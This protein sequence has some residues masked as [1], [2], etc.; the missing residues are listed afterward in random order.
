MQNSLFRE[1]AIEHQKCKL[2]GEVLIVPAASHT[3]VVLLLTLWVC[4]VFAWMVN[5]QYARQET[6]TGWLEPPSGVIK[7]FSN[8]LQGKIEQVLVT[9]G[10][11]VN[12]GQELVIVSSDRTLASGSS[13]QATL[14]QEYANQKQMLEDQL[15]RLDTTDAIDI[16]NIRRK[17]FA[18]QQDLTGLEAQ[19][20]TLSQRQELMDIRYNNFHTMRDEGHLA[21]IELDKMLEQKLALQSEAQALQREWVNLSNHLQLLESELITAPQTHLNESRQL[22]TKLS[23]L[24]LNIAQLNSQQSV[25]IKAS[26][27]GVVSNLQ[28]NVGHQ[29]LAKTPLLSLVPKDSL[30]Q[31]RLLVPIKAAGFIEEGQTIEVRYDAFPYQKFGLYEG[32]IT[33]ISDA[34][35]LPGELEFAPLNVNEP[36]Y[37]VYADLTSQTVSAYGKPLSL[38][39]GMTLSADVTLS[40][41]NL[42]EWVLEPLLSLKGRM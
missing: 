31:A 36:V 40:D 28:A 26:R 1:N 8:H 33:Q 32:H 9:E 23:E 17:V 7:V 39:S 41:R 20:T 15:L 16:A 24:S 3:L 25:V 21:S 14:L 10:Q 29:I 13:L 38:K 42:L 27:A 18:T 6:V 22:K 35:V 5:S 4:A 12:K 2:H 37:L 30:I 11:S 34:V 19:I